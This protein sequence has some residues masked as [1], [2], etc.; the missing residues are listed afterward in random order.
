TA[1]PTPGAA[2]GA[3]GGP[4]TAGWG[5]SSP[6]PEYKF[7]GIKS[8]RKA[9]EQTNTQ[10]GEDGVGV[11]GAGR[12]GE[13][14]LVLVFKKAK[15][16]SFPFGP[17]GIQNV[18]GGGWREWGGGGAN[19]WRGGDHDV[20]TVKLKN[21]DA[22]DLVAAVNKAFAGKGVVVVAEPNTNT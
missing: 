10:K 6:A 3:A 13:G 5:G 22:A 20:L 19:P 14:E 9:F 16:G 17:Q 2:S 18:I 15:G 4:A 1:P 12:V 21:A 7:V 11:C 8:D